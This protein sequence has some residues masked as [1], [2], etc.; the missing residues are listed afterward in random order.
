MADELSDIVAGQPQRLATDFNFTEGPLWHPDGHLFFV[1]I[2]ESLL[3]RWIPGQVPMVVKKDTGGGNGLTF[4]LEGRLIMCQHDPRRVARFEKD[5]TET[6]LADRWEG[7]RLNRPNDVVCRSDG[8]IYFS[9]PGLRV[10]PEERELDVSGV[11]RVAPDGTLSMATAD[12]DYP[13]GL[14]FSPDEKAL[15][16]ANSRPDRYIRA[17]DVQP[18]GSLTNGRVFADMSAPEE[19]V[20]DG[21]KVDVKGNVFCA[22]PGGTWVFDATGRRLGIIHTPEVPA[23]LAF[24]GSDLRTIFFTARTSIYTLRVR[25]PGVKAPPYKGEGA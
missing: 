17:F 21:V 16:V 20:P 24:G 12:C 1:D 14:A 4:D 18:D 15:Y 5:G 19:Q 13:N 25:T 10:P 7:K 2:P 23:N 11:M 9:D 22:G 8:S 3:Y 6:V